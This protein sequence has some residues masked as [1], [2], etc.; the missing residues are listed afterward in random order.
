[1][2]NSIYNKSFVGIQ[3]NGTNYDYLSKNSVKHKSFV[4]TQLNDQTVLF[5]TIQFRISHLLGHILNVKQF[6]LAHR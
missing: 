4:Y 6:Y 2:N 1:M 3:V 5:L